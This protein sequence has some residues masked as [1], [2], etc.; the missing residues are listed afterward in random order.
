MRFRG[1]CQGQQADN[2]FA[3][4]VKS[5]VAM[6][7]EDGIRAGLSLDEARRQALVRLGGVEQV[8][9]AYRE[10]RTLP[11][12]ESLVSDAGYGLRGLLRSPGF[13]AVAVL[14]LALGIGATSTVFTVADA[15]LLRSW[16][17][18]E[19]QR[20]V[21]IVAST[22]QGADY[23]FSYPDAVDLA[24]QSRTLEGIIAY[25]R[26]AATIHS[27]SESQ[28]LL[29]EVVSPNY[30]SLLGTDPGL[31]R[32]FAAAAQSGQ[33]C[34]VIGNA[35]WQR[36]FGSDPE[37][38]GKQILLSGRNYTV[39]G[40][41][42]RGFRGMTAFIPAELWFPITARYG[43]SE[44]GFRGFELVGRLRP[45]FT[46]AQAQAELEA[47]GQRLAQAYPAV[48][49]G[50]T[51]TV[52]SE[53]QRLREAATPTAMLMG[54]VGIVLLICCANVAGLILARGDARRK[55]IAMRLALGATRFRIVRQLLTESMLLALIGAG[56]GLIVAVELFRLQSALMP[57]AKFSLGLDLHLNAAA[58]LFT[59]AVSML[60]VILCGLLPAIQA[61]KMSCAPALKSDERGGPPRRFTLRGSLVV[62]EIAMA[63]TLLT[64][65]G[66]VVKS[67]LV[68][69]KM[70]LGFDREKH[71]VFFDLGPGYDLARSAAYFQQAETSAAA[72]PGVRHAAL[73]Q[74]MLLSDF[75]G[76]A[77][78]RVSIP[79]IELPQGQTTIP[80]KFNAVDS[81][82]FQT[83]GTHLLDGR[84]FTMADGPHTARVA[85][86]SRTMAERY[87]P[88][89][90]AIG[91]QIVV[92]GKPCQVV[93]VAED[94]KIIQPHEA[95]EAYIYL[96][97]AQWP[98]G[99]ASLILESEQDGRPVIAA[100]R[101]VLQTMDR[102]APLDVRTVDYLMQQAFWED[103]ITAAF[104]GI[105]GLLAIFFGAL[106]LYGVISFAVN[107]RRREIGIRMAL[108]A[109]RND[110]VRMVLR[111]GMAFAAIGSVIGLIASLLTM[112]V[113]SSVLYGVKPT[114]PLAFAGSVAVVISV[115]L[116]ACWIPARRAASI[117]PMQALR[118]E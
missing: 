69:L 18:S 57:P 49:K 96:P 87:W 72:L 117:D 41:A 104:V 32:R 15:A 34:V 116:I 84:E 8:R 82:Y 30:F 23:S 16:P 40:L 47:T 60:A 52:I 7:T 33:P 70:N 77:E 78:K 71:L 2:D 89:S 98:R 107:R 28:A 3:A 108:G 12:I 85:I 55:E 99:E 22:P 64:A 45:E 5:H 92:D 110:V 58:I 86:V 50:R 38:V 73:A 90:T 63:A 9:Q 24:A 94:A 13:T 91:R 105:L 14:T 68:S 19:P 26:Y 102:N 4:E 65:S 81:G 59:I 62:A 113:L 11:L 80:V 20:M 35:V 101:N 46:P 36:F 67:F 54:A 115:S 48:D 25:A 51:V 37:L 114:D 1:L 27:G 74:R 43:A 111:E 39:V 79:G 103:R 83:V 100:M 61:T 29:D 93:G 31:G 42:P 76:G 106:G 10:R 66:L 56:L 75:G 6:H 53:R 118:T 88:A 97:F 17:A 95:L 109:E 44:R 21:R 112:R